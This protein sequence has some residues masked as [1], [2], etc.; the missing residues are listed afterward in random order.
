M[1]LE[2]LGLSLRAATVE[3]VP[4]L[5]ALRRQTMTEHQIVSGLEPSE[6]ERERRVLHRFECAQILERDGEP[7]GLFK[8]ARDGDAW[9]LIQIQVSPSLQGQG[10]GEALIRSLIAEAQQAKASLMLHVLHENPARNLYQRLGFQVVEKGPHEYTMRHE[11]GA[12]SG[13]PGASVQRSQ[14][15]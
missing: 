1:T 6:Q 2:S 4:F 7:V 10:I 13:A 8:V 9:Q 14:A 3:D 5:L 11:A 15:G 12:A